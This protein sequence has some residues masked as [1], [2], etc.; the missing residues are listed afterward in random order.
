MA[1][2]GDL[3]AFGTAGAVVAAVAVPLTAFA[4]RPRLSLAPG[5]EGV[6]TR[7][8]AEQYPWLRLVVRN[9]RRRRA[10]Q[11]TR[12][13]VE[14][15]RKAAGGEPVGMG[16]PELGWPSADVAP[17]SGVVVFA[18]AQRP[19]DFGHLGLI[20]RD[21][22]GKPVVTLANM[23]TILDSGG[24]WELDLALAMHSQ[25]LTIADRRELLP[26]VERGYVV[27]LLVGA[28]D[29]AARTYEVS[30]DWNG[31]APNPKAALESVHL[32]V[33]EVRPGRH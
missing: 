7:V 14:H 3:A 17:G 24:S 2:T 26:P 23:D 19:I 8:E 20:R 18:G 15:Y 32:A 12:V 21:N 22:D 13:M 11:D 27:R 28:E 9:S 10:A 25:G 6:H 30:V 33:R 4:R 31:A 5:V 16:S 29:G 1:W